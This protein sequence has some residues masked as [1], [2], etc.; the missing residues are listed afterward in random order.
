MTANGQ[1]DP[2]LVGITGQDYVDT[3]AAIQAE[4]CG[5][6]H[7]I[8]W[9]ARDLVATEFPPIRWAVDGVLADGLNLLAGSPKVGKSWLALGIGIAVAA[10]GRALG[11]I[12]VEQGDALYLALEDPPRRLKRRL[13]LIL[14]DETA[15]AGLDLW[16]ECPRLPEGADEIRRWLDA[17]PSAR[18][19]AVD[20]FAKFRPVSDQ[21]AG[22]YEN[23]YLAT[24]A[25]KQIAD[26]YGVCVA[27][28]HHT[29]KQSADDW[30]DSISGTNG[31]A[32][33]ADG[34]LVLRRQRGAAAAELLVTG[35]DVEEST[36]AL[37][38]APD[39]GAWTLLDGPA[40]DYTLG[41][42]RRAV[43]HLLRDQGALAPKAV[44]E[45]LALDHALIRQTL[46]RMV[47]DEQLDTDGSGLYFL[48]LSPVTAVTEVTPASDTSDGSDSA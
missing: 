17:H 48:P 31:L 32:G 26:E 15:P 25:L 39:L 7:R 43:L 35:R 37:S 40:E 2:R 23:D 21:K 9:S 38:F 10:G 46:R 36:R 24:L 1:V 33:G 20:V 11:T 14:G 4:P 18:Y 12:P 3:L 6:G 22:A 34:L 28:V 44:A 5:N 19:L 41:E 47:D 16:T 30:T 42:T 27:I 13:E 29:R 8:Q 45:H